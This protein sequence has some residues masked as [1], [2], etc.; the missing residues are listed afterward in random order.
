MEV[1]LVVL[2]VAAVA[3]VG[4]LLANR[5]P[6]MAPVAPS[7]GPDLERAVALAVAQAND[8][9]A[10]ERDLAVQAAVDQ[11]VTV[12][13][14][15]LGAGTQAAEQSLAG[16]HQ[17]IDAKLGE[18]Q[19]GMQDDLRRVT[20]LL[21]QL[22]DSTSER[23]G[24][25]DR[26]LQVHS[27]ITQ[28]LAG[29]A[30]SLREA[31]ASS[32]ARGQWGE[33][34]AEDVL[35]L[36]G[37]QERVNYVKRTAVE[38]EGRGIPDFTFLLPKGHVLFMDVKFPM[39]AYLRYLD[40]NTDA[41]RS[42][43]RAAFLRDVR[44]RVRELAR[45]EYSASDDRPAV[46]N[47]LLFVPNESLT[48]FIHEADGTLVEDALRQHVVICSP[49]TLFAYL[50]VIRQ[51]FDNFMIEQTSQ[52]I[53]GLLG[54]FSQQ[55][56]KYTE[57]IDKVKRQFEMVNKSFDELATTRRRQLERP[58]IAIDDLRRKQALPID[59]QLFELPDPEL[60]NVRELGA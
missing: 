43:H 47:V 31:L 51:A 56:G 3:A 1:V 57:A 36:A 55:W 40:A 15:Q 25:V 30:S 12:V 10:R 50:G 4:W 46:D 26:S 32:N 52:E 28:S 20:Q 6:V 49:L 54:K 16:R 27:E 24:Q 19:A 45:R 59:G 23:F 44:A 9:A 22:G 35:R 42:A 53:L 38:G 18:V 5:R 33:R 60:D 2:L 41:E 8:R 37:L 7:V 14:E 13:R 58:L 48:A 11:A 34:M 29:T 39:D 21:Q 17:L